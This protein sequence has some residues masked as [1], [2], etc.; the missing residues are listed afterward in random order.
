MDEPDEMTIAFITIKTDQGITGYGETGYLHPQATESFVNDHIAPILIGKNPL[1]NERIWDLLYTK[2]NPRAQTGVWSTAVS[3][4]DIAL[5]D[6]KG[7]QY[8]EPVWR[9]LGGANDSV[10]VYYTIGQAIRD[11]DRLADIATQLVSEGAE[12]IKIVVGKGEWSS[13]TVDAERVTAVREAIGDDIG[14]AI[15]ANYL[16]SLNDA[17]QLCNHLES[18]SIS[19][20]EEP[21][22][23]NDA[24]LLADLRT[25]TRIPIAA[26]QN[27]G[28]RFRHRE[29]IKG[30]AIDISLPNVCFTGGYTEAV[31]VA[32]MAD[33]FNI[34]IYHG[35]GW[36]FQNMHLQ[37]G[38]ANG[39]MVEFHD[40]VWEIGK[41]IYDSPPEPTGKSITLPDEPGLG[42][43]PDFSV[44][45]R[46]EN[47]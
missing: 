27:E 14:L 45:N 31:K 19:W 21:V 16:Y 24:L 17:L 46:Y 4:V 25:R 30:S 1:N 23:G 8:G 6:I 38:L 32:G 28:H 12:R 5:W 20:F 44:L 41:K 40:I 26:G 29:L 47:N 34:D 7:K 9:L 43:D 2:L 35:G 3:A 18:S 13:P 42:L 37:A 22:Y 39:Q 36:P 11:K 10:P 15:D 33:A